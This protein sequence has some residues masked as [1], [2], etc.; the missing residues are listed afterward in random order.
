MCVWA[1]LQN[2]T[3]G[4]VVVE[5]ASCRRLHGTDVVLAVSQTIFGA[6]G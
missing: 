1:L 2:A 4:V 3:L 5:G 6:P